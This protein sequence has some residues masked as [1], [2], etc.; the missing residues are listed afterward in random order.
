MNFRDII[1]IFLLLGFVSATA[2]IIAQLEREP[3]QELIHNPG[4]MEGIRGWVQDE[5]M[6]GQKIGEWVHLH[7]KGEKYKVDLY[8]YAHPARD[9]KETS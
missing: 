4:M 8:F 9:L 6:N 7:G 1:Y 3:E 2:T 5:Q